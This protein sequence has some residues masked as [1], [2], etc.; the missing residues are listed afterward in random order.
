MITTRRTLEGVETIFGL[1]AL[2][3]VVAGWYAGV[4]VIDWLARGHRG[5]DSAGPGGMA[6]R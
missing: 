4:C 6:Q 3:A 2:A 1:A 5:S